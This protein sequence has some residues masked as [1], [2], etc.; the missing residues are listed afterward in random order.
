MEVTINKQAKSGWDGP[1]FYIVDGDP[2]CEAL[3]YFTHESSVDG[4]ACG[5]CIV[6]PDGFPGITFGKGFNVRGLRKLRP[7]E[8]ITIEP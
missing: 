1:G 8:T 3:W 6:G 4:D 5:V 2:E 7:G